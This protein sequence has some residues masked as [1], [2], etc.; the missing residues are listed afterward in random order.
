[1]LVGWVHPD[2]FQRARALDE[3]LA[4]MGAT[5]DLFALPRRRTQSVLADAGSPD[6][7]HF[8]AGRFDQSIGSNTRLGDGCRGIERAA[9]FAAHS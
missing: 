8:S 7:A 5:L 3:D 1:V 2:P 4:A 6:R 9:E